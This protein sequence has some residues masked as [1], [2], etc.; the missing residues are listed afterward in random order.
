MGRGSAYSHQFFMLF[1]YEDNNEYFNDFLDEVAD[2]FGME[3]EK[4]LFWIGR[5]MRVIAE[6]ERLQVGIDSCGGLPCIFA[7]PKTYVPWNAVDSYYEKEYN[8]KRDV[9][10][11]FSLLIKRYNGHG[12]K[13]K[14]EPVFRYPTSAWTS[15]PYVNGKYVV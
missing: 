10:K 15:S 2:A 4:T 13:V 9:V 1:D 6:N 12:K 7:Q 14:K 3:L 8:I 5:E 11:A